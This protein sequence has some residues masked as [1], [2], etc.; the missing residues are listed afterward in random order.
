MRL[1]VL[2]QY[3]RVLIVQ[4]STQGIPKRASKEVWIKVVSFYRS[5]A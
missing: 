2:A 5:A 4:K 3:F 1:L